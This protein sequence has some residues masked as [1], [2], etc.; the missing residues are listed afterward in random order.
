[1]RV[2]NRP[3]Q[4]SKAQRGYLSNEQYQDYSEQFFKDIY[5]YLSGDVLFDKENNTKTTLTFDANL[6]DYKALEIH[7]K[8]SR[9]SR[10]IKG[11]QIIQNPVGSCLNVH[12]LFRSS[13]TKHLGNTSLYSISDNAITLIAGSA[14]EF[15]HNQAPVMNANNSTY[16]TGVIGYK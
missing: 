3:K 7:Y 2:L 8:T 12:V 16:I 14:Y 1:M 13:S 9:D 4:V 6:N 15:E 5:D 10:L 11:S